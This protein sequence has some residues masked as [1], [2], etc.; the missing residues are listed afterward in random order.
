MEEKRN[1]S[2]VSGKEFFERNSK[3]KLTLDVVK[4]LTRENCVLFELS[5]FNHAT[6]LPEEKKVQYKEN[7]TKMRE[8]WFSSSYVARPFQEDN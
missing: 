5:I 7:Q 3:E 2:F 8:F 1:T 4:Q 6:T